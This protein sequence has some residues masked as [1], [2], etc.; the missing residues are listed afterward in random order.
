M[1]ASLRKVLPQ[2]GLIPMGQA[3]VSAGGNIRSTADFGDVQVAHTVPPNRNKGQTNFDDLVRAYRSAFEAL[4]D[5][6][7]RDVDDRVRLR[8]PLGR[9]A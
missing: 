9:Y 1:N 3:V 6:L 8:S 2:D 7:D 5:L 4:C